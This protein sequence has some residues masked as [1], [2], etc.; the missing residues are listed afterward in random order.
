MRLGG[1]EERRV[2]GEWAAR[3]E[4]LVEVK[5]VEGRREKR[6]LGWVWDWTTRMKMG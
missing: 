2:V 4:E 6:W 3:E 5:E 1:G